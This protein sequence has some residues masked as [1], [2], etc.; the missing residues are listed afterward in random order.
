MNREEMNRM[1]RQLVPKLK[2][3]LSIIVTK[4]SPHVFYISPVHRAI[5]LHSIHFVGVISTNSMNN[6]TTAFYSL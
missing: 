2:P 6:L 4:S 1:N 5:M 3:F